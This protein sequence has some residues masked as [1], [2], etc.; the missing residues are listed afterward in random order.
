MSYTLTEIVEQ[1]HSCN[2]ECEAGALI[3]NTHFH[4]LELLAQAERDELTKLDEHIPRELLAVEQRRSCHR[5]GVVFLNVSGDC[6]VCYYRL[7]AARYG[8]RMGELLH[9]LKGES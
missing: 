4:A 1:L 9:E 6:P 3:N 8:R 7:M 2:Y 5:C